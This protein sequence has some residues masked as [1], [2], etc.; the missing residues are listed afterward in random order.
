MKRLNLWFLLLQVGCAV[1]TFCLHRVRMAHPTAGLILLLL[2]ATAGAAESRPIATTPF[3]RL[4]TGM[5]TAKIS[6]ISVDAAARCVVTASKDKTARVWEVS[7]GKLLQTLRP[8]IGEGNEGR[9]DAVAL[10][11]DGKEVAVGG[12]TGQSGSDNFHIY[13]FDRATGQLTRTIAGL[14]NGIAHLIYSRDGQFLAASLGGGEGIRVYRR[15]DLAEVARDSDYGDSSWWLD[16]DAQGRLV[17]SCDDGYVRLYNAAFQLQHKTRLAGGKEPFA[18]RFSPDGQ[19]IAVGFNDSTAV[20][21]LSGAELS[22]R[23]APDTQGVNNGSLNSV[24]W[25][26]DGQTLYAGGMYDDGTGIN[27]VLAWSEAGH[28]GYR[29]YAAGYTTVIDIQ[30]LADGRVLYGT[31][32][33]IWGILSRNGQKLHQA[34]AGI[35][36]YRDSGN[37][38]LQLSPN[39][40]QFAFMQQGTARRFDLNLGEEL[41][42]SKNSLTPAK[43]TAS[44]FSVTNWEG[45]RHPQFNQQDIPLRDYE[46]S[47]SLAIAADEQHFVLGADWYLRYFDQQGKQLWESA[48]PSAAWAVNLSS[49]GRFAVAAFSD[50]TIRWFRVSD[51]KEQLAF[52]PH[53]DGKRWV[54]WT[55][56]GFYNASADGESLIG[57]HLNQGDDKAGQ[58]VSVQQLGKLFYRPDLITARLR[59]DEAAIQTALAN[60]G[61]VRKVLAEGLPPKLELLSPAEVTQNQNDFTLEL[62]ALDQ[63]G[64]ISEVVYKINGAVIAGRGAAG[65]TTPGRDPFI[66]HFS[67]PTGDSTIEA[68]VYDKNNQVA[69]RAIQTIVHVTANKLPITLHIL[70]VGIS[71]YRDRALQLKYAAK[72]AQAVVEELKQRGAGLFDRVQVNPTLL[73]KQATLANIEAAFAALKPQVQP[74]DVFV[75]YLAGHGKALDGTYHFLPWELVYQNESSLRDKSLDQARLQRLLASLDATKSVVLLDTCDAGAFVSNG[76]GVDQKAAIDRLMKF[77]G[78]AVLSAT[79]DNNMALEGYEKHGVF[80]YALLEG[81]KQPKSKGKEHITIGE[82]ADFVGDK[83]PEIT[84]KQWHYEQFPMRDLKGMNFPI[85]MRQ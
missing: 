53:A 73:D 79:S 13:F 72:D 81:L 36:N 65:I 59:G 39:G 40:A 56:E 62:K 22:L 28:G 46:M 35:V 52:F 47:R 4:E 67:L 55:P 19:Q 60:V 78:R 44:A 61:D 6:R 69:S 76:R 41:S 75:L 1:R 7:T 17:S 49:D 71:D 58:F 64:G 29:R 21:V 16:F 11:P 15:R 77:T 68:I 80:T 63:G 83:V 2:S 14:P 27:P 33:P 5:H 82:L 70:A 42:T 50:G 26:A 20:A 48:T 66:R 8:P 85:G 18:V 9:L 74:Q 31:A 54:L 38:G 30:T 84:L 34:D 12:F 51:G 43:T 45:G 25:S 23:Y 37:G 3:L 32:D 57:Y 10:S 24:A